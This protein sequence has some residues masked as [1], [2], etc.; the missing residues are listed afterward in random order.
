MTCRVKHNSHVSAAIEVL[1]EQGFEGLGEVAFEL[2]MENNLLS[3]LNHLDT[4]SISVD[5]VYDSKTKTNDRETSV[6]KIAHGH[7]KD[8][9][10][11]LKQVVL[12]LVVNGP[13]SMP[14]FMEPLNGNS[15][16][17]ASFHETIKKVEAFKKKLI[18][19]RALNGWLILRSIPRRNY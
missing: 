13:S 12:S 10:P 6:I 19:T 11:D 16:D 4:T 7:S 14:I 2:A 3:D 15:S 18:S 5:G 8:C 9:R 1:C 17:K